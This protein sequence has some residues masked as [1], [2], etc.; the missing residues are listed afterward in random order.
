MVSRRTEFVTGN[1]FCHPC[2]AFGA[3]TMDMWSATLGMKAAE[4]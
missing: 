2:P 1:I 3:S 4:T